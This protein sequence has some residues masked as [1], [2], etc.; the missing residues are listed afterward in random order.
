M[1][2]YYSL[3][4]ISPSPI[5]DDEITIGII[6][7]GDNNIFV[8]FSKKRK[9]IASSLL[10]NSKIIDVFANQII[11]KVQFINKEKT[12]KTDL[13]KFTSFLSK[14]YMQNLNISHNGLLRFTK[15]SFIN[16]PCN[17]TNFKNLFIKLVDSEYPSITLKKSNFKS[18]I[19]K[20]LIAKVE[21]RMHTHYKFEKNGPLNL[22]FNFNID[23]IGKN[24]S[25][26]AL[27]A[28][29]FSESTIDTVDKNIFHYSLVKEQLINKFGN[30]SNKFILIAD[31][32]SAINSDQHRAWEFQ[33]NKNIFDF[34]N[35]DEVPAIV[36]EI[37][38]SNIK[39]FF[40]S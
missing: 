37:E 36:A 26:Y 28:I 25:I 27:K 21:T 17:E 18:K 32:P 11:K 31:E 20:G 9:S 3:I 2:N 7:Q 8:E 5:I 22:Y 29:D 1:E 40:K 6:M 23:A 14:D 13:F 10:K 19:E 4:K 33:M 16:L 24:G 12:A 38:D 15:P 30:N 39:K 34:K 35:S